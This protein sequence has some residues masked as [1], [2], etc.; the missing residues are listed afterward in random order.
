[1]KLSC[2]SLLRAL[3][4]VSFVALITG[5]QPTD[6]PANK[7]AASASLTLTSPSAE[8]PTLLAPTN[9][10][11]NNQVA[12]ALVDFEGFE[13]QVKKLAG[14]IVVVDAWSTSCPPCMREYPHL[15]SLSRRWPDQVACVSLNV[16]YIGIKS[17]PPESYLPKVTEFLEKQQSLAVTNLMS[18]EADSDVFEKLKID[19]IPAILIYDTTGTL[20]KT[21]SEANSGEDGLTYD[22]DVVP[23]IEAM[24]RQ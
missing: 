13:A 24:V 21:F 16:D 18:T 12:V 17:K 15:V 4:I 10:E 9:A 6:T 23:A 14:K 3:Q 11:P 20:V 19:S 8:A 2:M 22:A 1:M 7:E 5:C